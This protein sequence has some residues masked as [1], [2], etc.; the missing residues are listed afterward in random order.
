MGWWAGG[1]V[2]WWAGG[3][4]GWW[5]GGLVG[6]WAGGLVGWWAGGLVG[7]WAGALVGWWA[8]GLVGWWAGGLVLV[9][10]LVEG[11]DAHR[12][13]PNRGQRRKAA[14][15]SSAERAC[16]LIKYC[17]FCT[18][19]GNNLVLFGNFFPH[20]AQIRETAKGHTEDKRGM[21]QDWPIAHQRRR[22]AIYGQR[23]RR[24]QSNMQHDWLVTHG[25]TARRSSERQE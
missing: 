12:Q 13:T 16:T 9:L 19:S 14:G 20:R 5:A 18:G 15:Q 4:V 11:E 7:W 17:P 25:G 8:G 3:L 1:L 21:Q 24:G 23:P 10:V 2:G 22:R 6:W